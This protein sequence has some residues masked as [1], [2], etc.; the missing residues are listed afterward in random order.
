MQTCPDSDNVRGIYIHFPFCIK[1]CSYCDFYSVTIRSE[2]L[3]D[4]YVDSLVNELKLKSP[5]Y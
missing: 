1:K 4:E 5:K 3:L 2:N